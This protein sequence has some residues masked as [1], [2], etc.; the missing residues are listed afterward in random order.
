VAAPTLTRKPIASLARSHADPTT[1][2]D[3]ALLVATAALAAFGVLAIYTARYTSISLA[4]ADTLYY[5]KRQGL[6]LLLGIVLM[7]G[8]ML[9]DYHR[10]RELAIVAYVG[11]IALLVGV[12]V[13][14]KVTNGAQAWYQIGPFQLQP[15]ELAKVTLVLVLAA[16]L[17][18]DRVTGV[19]FPRFVLALA[20]V[21]VP[22]GLTL[23]QPDLG[24]AS[25]LVVI[26]MG[27]LLVAGADWRHIALVTAL[28]VITLGVVVGTG[29]MDTY[30]KDRI[31]SFLQQTPNA[32]NKDLVYNVNNSKA[33]IS[34]G[35]VTGTG[36]LKGSLTNGGYVPENHTDFVFSAIGEQFGMVGSGLLLLLYAFISL[37]IWRTAQLAKDQLGA[38]L[39]AGALAVLVWHVFENVGMNMGIMPVTGIPL[40]FVSYGGSSTIAFCILI[41]L[42]E[43]VHMR[44]YA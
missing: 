37:R 20:L 3:W 14:G 9:V 22:A 5:V 15:S 36:Y 41:G 10:L 8:T 12:L 39:C 16:Y 44:R 4:G 18:G 11:T 24:T 23:L 7:V 30:Q 27:V 21:A 29:T 34:L 40:P 26:T 1:H 25:V 42:V 33:A 6:A 38:L 31:A 32:N 13:R 2:V 28:A 35:G 17:S 43:S 19:P